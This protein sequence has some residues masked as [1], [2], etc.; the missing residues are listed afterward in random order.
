MKILEENIEK[1]QG[2]EYEQFGLPSPYKLGNIMYSKKHDNITVIIQ[3]FGENEGDFRGD[4]NGVESFTDVRLASIEEILKH[5]EQ[6][7]HE[8]RYETV[9]AISPDNK[10]SDSVKL[11]KSRISDRN[12][13]QLTIE[14]DTIFYDG[15]ILLTKNEYTKKM[16]ELMKPTEVY[17][18]CQSFRVKPWV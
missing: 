1:Y 8:L 3:G 7:I 16:L 10:I 2:F 6:L 17:K 5:R 14:N 9:Y 15:R 4:Q 12:Q 11:V 18:I 13:M